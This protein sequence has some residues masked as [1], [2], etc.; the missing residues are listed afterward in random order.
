MNRTHYVVCAF[1]CFVSCALGAAVMGLAW[2]I[3]V[4]QSC[5]SMTQ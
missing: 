5:A 2:A 1:V 3:F 4:G